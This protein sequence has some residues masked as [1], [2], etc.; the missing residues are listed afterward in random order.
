MHIR[1]PAG[2]ETVAIDALASPR[3]KRVVDVGCGR[4]QP[5]V[6]AVAEAAFVYAFDPNADAVA[7]AKAAISDESRDRVRFGVHDIDALDVERARFDLALCGWSLCCVPVEGVVNALRTLHTA[8]VP[9]GFVVDTQPVSAHPPVEADS[10]E[11]GTLD[12]REWERTIREID[13]RFNSAFQ[14]RLFALQE[15]RSFVVTDSFDDGPE[16]L[17]TVRAWQGTRIPP[18]LEQR[19]AR[20]RGS[21]HVHQD[22]R[23]R[24]LRAL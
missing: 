9:G 8:L 7:E 12:M 19:I 22:V 11:L 6:F 16:L 3:G 23:L 4:G 18:A 10:D 2:A 5:T 20:S 14:D 13:N 24:L 1:D 17:A 21:V 15:E